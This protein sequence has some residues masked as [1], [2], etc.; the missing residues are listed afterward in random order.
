LSRKDAK[1]Q[2]N[3]GLTQENVKPA[4]GKQGAKKKLFAALRLCVSA[5][6]REKK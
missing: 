2:R 1:A 5:P 3:K 4:Y 6:L